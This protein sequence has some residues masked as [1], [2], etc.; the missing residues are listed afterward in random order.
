MPL[1]ICL[2]NPNFTPE[3]NAIINPPIAANGKITTQETVETRERKLVQQQQ[4]DSTR[5]VTCERCK[6]LIGKQH[7]YCYCCGYMNAHSN[8]GYPVWLHP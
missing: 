8:R 4:R 3:E 6:H 2:M 5:A 1:G 7:N